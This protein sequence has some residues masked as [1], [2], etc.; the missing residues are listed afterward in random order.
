MKGL[1]LIY[2]MRQ[3][4]EVCDEN[5]GVLTLITS[6]NHW[7]K[8]AELLQASY[9]VKSF[10]IVQVGGDPG[11]GPGYAGG[12]IS[13]SWLGNSFFP[14]FNRAEIGWLDLC[15]SAETAS[16]HKSG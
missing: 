13:L 4:C 9:K 2:K 8:P 10:Y 12:I 14:L 5:G 3:K 7:I 15:T 1:R 6:Q 16:P 11:V